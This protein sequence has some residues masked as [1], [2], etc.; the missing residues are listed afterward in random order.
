MQV[1]HSAILL[2][3]LVLP[4]QVNQG[5]V[6]EMSKAQCHSY[7]PVSTIVLEAKDDASRAASELPFQR[8]RLALPMAAED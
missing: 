8:R 5:S 2:S 4:S 3:V 7:E 1:H 6:L